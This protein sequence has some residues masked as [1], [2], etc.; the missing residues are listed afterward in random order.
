MILCSAEA[1]EAAG[2]PADR[3]VFP[4]AGSDAHDHWFVSDRW[5]LHAS[6]AIAAC[7][8]AVLELTGTGIDDIGPIDLYS[9]FPSAVQMGAAALGLPIDDSDRPL[10]VTGGLAFAGGPGNNYVTHSIATMVQRLRDRPDAVG[11]VTALGWYATKHSV[12]LYSCGPPP[13]GPFRA[14]TVQDEVDRQPARTVAARYDGPIAIEAS[15]VVYERDGAP[16][17]GIVAGLTP[18]GRRAWGN[19]RQPDLLKALTTEE[20]DGRPAHL[21]TDGDV[22][23]T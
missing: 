14:S 5:A 4:W 7:G 12:G 23:I 9:C 22:D 6:P 2:V 18:D 21:Q 3:W 8:R 10:T 19:T 17:L 16:S 1:A 20:L 11:L 15:T 13:Q